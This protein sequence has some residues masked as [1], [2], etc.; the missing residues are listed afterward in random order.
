MLIDN[1]IIEEEEVVEQLKDN[2]VPATKRTPPGKPVAKEGNFI[3]PRGKDIKV[4]FDKKYGLYM[5]S[6]PGGGALPAF[7]SGKYTEEKRAREAIEQYLK[8]YWKNRT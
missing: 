5:I 4:V 8:V 2:S 3:T 7:L 1:R 6:F